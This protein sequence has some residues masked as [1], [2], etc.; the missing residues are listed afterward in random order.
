MSTA[1]QST[2]GLTR[3][4]IVYV[5]LLCALGSATFFI[6]PKR[7]HRRRKH[8]MTATFTEKEPVKKILSPKSRSIMFKA[9]SST[10]T[11]LNSVINKLPAS[12]LVVY[13]GQTGAAMQPRV[14]AAEM[15]DFGVAAVSV[16]AGLNKFGATADVIIP[17]ATLSQNP[18]HNND[19]GLSLGFFAAIASRFNVF[20]FYFRSLLQTSYKKNLFPSMIDLVSL[21]AMGKC[22]IMNFRGSEVRLHSKFKVL[23]PFNY[24]DENPS[25]LQA[26]FKEDVMFSMAHFACNVAHVVIVP[27]EELAGYV[28]C[29]TVILPRAVPPPLHIPKIDDFADF[30]KDQL[31]VVHAPSR[32]GVKGTAHVLAAVE[33]LKKTINF[34]FVLA[35][36][37]NHEK[38]LAL[39]RRA[40]ILIDQLRIGW[41][42]VLST[43]GM[44]AGAAVVAYIRD[45]LL[46]DLASHNGGVL[47]IANANPK[48]IQKVLQRLL[49]DDAYRKRVAKSGKRFV[50]RYHS[51]ERV[52]KE[53]VGIYKKYCP[54]MG[55]TSDKV[56]AEA[57]AYADYYRNMYRDTYGKHEEFVEM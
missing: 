14:F 6:S 28:P 34:K 36:K 24:V 47:P 9:A 29:K 21:K 16:L 45:D 33:V 35:E 22:V 39:Y 51:S 4:V 44:S 52:S 20:H 38:A 55:S 2:M 56:T 49:Q 7:H 12:K 11:K 26:K 23:S 5:L 53:L 25:N 57:M 42:G 41:Y 3:A 18:I 32:R 48:T 50:D 43:E 40:D 46:H 8:A 1:T 19:I 54:M 30:P 31:V 13:H 27:D 17:K 37:L 15:K 10:M